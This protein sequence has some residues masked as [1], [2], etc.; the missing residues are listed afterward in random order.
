MSASVGPAPGLVYDWFTTPFVLGV[1]WLVFLVWLTLVILLPRERITGRA[2]DP[3]SVP[4]SP[5]VNGGHVYRTPGRALEDC[6]HQPT[7]WRCVNCADERT[8]TDSE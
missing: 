1:A 7:V 2:D 4:V 3:A 8:S 5:C 6:L